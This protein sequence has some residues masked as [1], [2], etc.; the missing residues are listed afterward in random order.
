MM[1]YVAGF[2][3]GILNDTQIVF[4]SGVVALWTGGGAD[5]W[6]YEIHEEKGETLVDLRTTGIN[7]KN[8]G[9]NGQ[10]P[11]GC[12]IPFYFKNPTTGKF[13]ILM[14]RDIDWPAGVPS[15]FTSYRKSMCGFTVRGNKIVPQH[16]GNMPMCSID[17]S[18]TYFVGSVI[19][20]AGNINQWV[21]MSLAGYVPDN[22]RQIAFHTVLSGTPSP[23]FLSGLASHD[24]ATL[25]NYG[26]SQEV[27]GA[28]VRIQGLGTYY[29]KVT[30]VAS[31]LDIYCR[32]AKVTEFV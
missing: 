9:T 17:Y 3:P 11:N 32:E 6:G 20:A 12:Y 28:R 23:C 27:G 30:A 18:Q 24:Y 4:E 29:A 15:G 7:G 14:S 10:V 16:I 26:G 1:Y 8:T 19:G 31:R 25:C 22:A 2:Q 5:G 21:Q 13:G